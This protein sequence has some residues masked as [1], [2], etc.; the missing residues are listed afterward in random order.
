MASARSREIEMPPHDIVNAERL[1][2]YSLVVNALDQLFRVPG[3][4]WRFGLDSIIG[5]IPGAGDIAMATV[6]AY[7]LVVAFQNGAP[8]S[9]QIRMLLNLLVDAAVGAIPI[10]GDLFDFAFKANVRNQRL[11]LGWLERPDRTRRSSSLLLSAL[12]LTLLVS[13]TGAVWL[14]VAAGRGLYRLIAGA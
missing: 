5:L 1:R 3:T 13:V 8:A 10:A 7:G 14:A 6:G 2:R 9:I 11:L 4:R 12:L